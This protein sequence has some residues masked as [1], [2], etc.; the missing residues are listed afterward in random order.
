MM[1][2]EMEDLVGNS[3]VSYLEQTGKRILEL[4]KIEQFGDKVVKQLE[5]EGEHPYLIKRYN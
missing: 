2:I 5:K 4:E 3:F 1:Y